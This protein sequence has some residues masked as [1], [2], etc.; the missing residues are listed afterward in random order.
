MGRL[1]KPY[2]EFYIRAITESGDGKALI[3]IQ[4]RNIND[5]RIL[6][7]YAY[8][9]IGFTP[10]EI[11]EKLELLKQFE[12]DETRTVVM[13]G[14]IGDTVYQDGVGYDWIIASYGV[15]IQCNED[16]EWYSLAGLSAV[17]DDMKREA[18]E[19]ALKD[20]AT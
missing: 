13:P 10:S 2:N 14:K 8:E 15:L 18:A 3:P 20:G 1:T 5:Q 9:D 11:L 4:P 16:S 7:L 17:I 6:K 12:A 19:A